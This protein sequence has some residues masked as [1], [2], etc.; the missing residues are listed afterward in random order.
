MPKKELL[1]AVAALQF[2]WKE[3]CWNINAFVAP[4]G[5]RRLEVKSKPFGLVLMP[6]FEIYYSSDKKLLEFF[7]FPYVSY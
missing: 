1:A 2:P 6:T 3:V 7:G 5:L 4:L